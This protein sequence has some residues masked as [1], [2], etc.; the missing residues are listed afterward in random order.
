M[1]DELYTL[2]EVWARA[3]YSTCED[4]TE[5]QA[6]AVRA[7]RPGEVCSPI[8]YVWIPRQYLWLDV[9]G[10]PQITNEEDISR[11]APR[12]PKPIPGW[13]EA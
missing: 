5:L 12:Q 6:N 9:F 10:E 13:I 2:A 3:P 7:L 1:S 11:V 8:L 4:V